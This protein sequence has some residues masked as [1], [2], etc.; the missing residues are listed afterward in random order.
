MSVVASRALTAD[1]EAV[2]T[3]SLKLHLANA[4]HSP[5]PVPVIPGVT[6]RTL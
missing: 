2:Y 3:A 6:N 1:F 5:L 4:T